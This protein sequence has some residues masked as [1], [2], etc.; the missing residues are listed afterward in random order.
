MLYSATGI[1][2]T[3]PENLVNL[4]FR[5]RG[6]KATSILKKNGILFLFKRC[7]VQNLVFYE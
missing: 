6:P 1:N 4:N 7:L 5:A 2:R 3:T